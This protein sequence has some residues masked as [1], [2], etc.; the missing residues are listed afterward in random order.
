M[1]AN[2]ITLTTGINGA[3][4]TISGVISGDGN[5]TKTGDGSLALSGINTFKGDLTISEG[6]VTIAGPDG[7]LAPEVDVVNQGTYNVNTTGAIPLN[8]SGNVVLAMG[9]R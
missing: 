8:G 6:S 2:G 7:T 3:A 9:S 5:L 1:L 4:D